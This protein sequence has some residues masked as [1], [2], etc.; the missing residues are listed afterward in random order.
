MKPDSLLKPGLTLASMLVSVPLLAAEFYV[1]PTGSDSNPGTI[2]QPFASLARGQQAASPGDTVWLRGGEYTFSGTNIVVGAPLDKSG[3]EG[4]RINYWAYKDEVP[5]FDFFKLTTLARMKGFSVTGN[6]LHFRGLEM[7]GVQQT[8]FNVH[9]SWCIRVEGGSNNIFE[10]L[11]LHHNMGPGFFIAAGASNLVLNCDSHHNYDVPRGGENAD[12]FGCHSIGAG[13]RFHGCRSWENSDDGY[14]LINCPGTSTIEYCWSW[15]NGFVPGTDQPAGNGAGFKSGGFLLNTIR[16]PAIIPSHH[17][18]F[19]LSVSNRVQGFYA[20]YHPNTLE[21]YNN[22]AFSNPKNFDLQTVVNPV[23][24]LLRNNLAYGSGAVLASVTRSKPDDQFNS[25]NLPDPVTDTDFLSVSPA[26]MDAPRQPDGS[27]PRLTF[28]HPAPGSKLIDAGTNVGLPFKGKAPDIGAFEFDAQPAAAAQSA[29]SAAPAA[30]APV[31]T[32]PRDQLPFTSE[33]LTNLNPKLPTLFI[34]GD[35]TAARGNPAARGWAALLIDYFD[36]N[37]VNLV[38]QGVGGARFNTYLQQGRWDRVMAAVKAGDY[39]VIEFGHNSGPLPGIGEETQES[40]GRGGGPATVM[41]T[42]GWYL[43]KFIA[44]VRAKG[45]IPIVSTITVR[46]KWTDGK[47]ERLKEQQ[48][49]QGGMSDWSR[50][51]AAQKKTLLVDHTTIIAD[52]YDQLGKAEVDRF[53]NGTEYLHTNTTGAIVNTEAFIA[54]LKAIPDMPLVSFLNDKGKAIP[55][56]KPITA[57]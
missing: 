32:V 28:L 16:F 20:N 46:N 33:D 49:G 4:K 34:T 36:T 54:G 5:V 44:D 45:G 18:H 6:W 42:H 51:V 22:T 30:R 29:Q 11:N 31:P 10:R 23:V 1:A 17:I 43:R 47:A 48:P 21:F 39:V 7:R 27:L 41:R 40:P 53:F 8:L 14:D 3:E 12:G 26:G 15:H 35:S 37:K 25:W 57:K 24:H 50:Q 9:E 2:G 19:N 55:T 56:Y 38:N 13:N 52:R